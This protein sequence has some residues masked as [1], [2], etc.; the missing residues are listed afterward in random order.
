MHVWVSTTD[1][2]RRAAH[3]AQWQNLELKFHRLLQHGNRRAR[4]ERVAYASLRPTETFM[5]ACLRPTEAARFRV[6]ISANNHQLIV[7]GVR[8]IQTSKTLHALRDWRIFRTWKREY[9]CVPC[10]RLKCVLLLWR[11][12]LNDRSKLK[13]QCTDVK[14]GCGPSVGSSLSPHSLS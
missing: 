7:A 10:T 14:S 8:V 13:G 1:A 2:H 6:R 4:R 12:S 3:G 11:P 5:R 9:A